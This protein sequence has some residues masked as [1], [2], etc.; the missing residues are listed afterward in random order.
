MSYEEMMKDTDALVRRVL[1]QNAIG[2]WIIVAMLAAAIIIL[3]ILK[4]NEHREKMK[5]LKAW[6]SF[7]K[8]TED[9]HGGQ[10]NGAFK[11]N[12]TQDEETVNGVTFR[13]MGPPTKR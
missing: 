4:I 5:A 8:E 6:S 12:V 1:I 11:P 13:K 2:E 7:K 10:W 9:E 3:L